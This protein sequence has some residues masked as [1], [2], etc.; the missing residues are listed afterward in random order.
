MTFVAPKPQGKVNAK[1]R[2][3]LLLLSLATA[4]WFGFDM[5]RLA[6]RE[7]LW[8]YRPLFLFLF[9]WFGIVLFWD[10]FCCRGAKQRRWLILSTLGGLLLG[11]GFPDLLPVPVLMFTG[12]V[13]ML[14]V[15]HEITADRKH[16][17][18]PILAYA[19]H[20]FAVWNIIA[21]YW[22]GN[23]A[24]AAGLF[25]ILVNSLLMCIPFMLFHLCRKAMPKLGY[26]SLIVFWITF[27]YNHLNWELTWPW[28]TLGNSFAEFPALVQWYEYT[29]VF[30]GTLWIL[31]LNI[32]LFRKLIRKNYSTFWQ[33]DWRWMQIAMILVLPILVS[34]MIYR[35]YEQRGKPVEVAVVQ[36]NY[37][38]HYNKFS[39]PVSIQMTQYLQLS[40]SVIDDQTDFLI[41]PESSFG[42]AE[43]H[44]LEDFSAVRR[45]REF[46]LDYPDLKLVTGLNAFTRFR[47]GEQLTK[48]TRVDINTAGD[49]TY[50]EVLNVAVQLSAASDSIQLYKKSKL[51][52]G[53]EIF[54]FQNVLS[55]FK[56]LVDKLG[57]T[58]AGVGT[59]KDRTPFSGNRGRVAPV[60]CYESVFG[61][62][63]AGYVRNGAEAAFI[64]TND[65]WWDNTGGHRQH[66][67]FAS[68]RSIET[69]R[70]IARS[71]NSGISAFI[72]QRGDIFQSTRYDEPAAIAS[73][74]MFDDSLTFYVRWGDYIARLA[75][76]CSLMLTLNLVVKSWQNRLV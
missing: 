44:T 15:E 31:V 66:L 9:A 49:T 12:F 18:W 1:T 55:I 16:P 32:L 26:F 37:E 61:E 10:R 42:Y 64:V 24:L 2:L 25:A 62:Y 69:R 63:F 21:T 28:L 47:P 51:V 52:P 48:N 71:A 59:Q 68:L 30:G 29:G 14:I 13:P 39:I 6:N 65:G 4:V 41:F 67:Y 19:Y 56:P 34:L 70:S 53:P 74:I 22:V 7:Q 57:G 50:F 27:E 75:L 17:F 8:G 38:P 60:I 72:N 73:T 46:L 76:F 40:N 23:S 5:F 20:F 35:S 54:P 43:T 58:T 33:F 3:V 36:P 45:L 11:I